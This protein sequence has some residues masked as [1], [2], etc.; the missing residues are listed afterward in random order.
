MKIENKSKKEI[1]DL[2]KEV[3]LSFY[4]RNIEEKKHYL[5]DDFLWIGAFDFQFATNK[6]QFLDIISSELNS[7]PF[8]MI[9]EEFSLL[10]KTR[11]SYIV[12]AKFKLISISDDKIVIRTHTRLTILWK[13]IH[14]ELKL[15]HVHGSNA[16]DI[17]LTLNDE[18]HDLAADKSFVDYLTSLS[19]MDN[20]NKV[21]FKSIDG[22]YRY[23]A[24]DE[25]IYLEAK[26]QKTILHTR[27]ET[28]EIQGLLRENAAKLPDNFFRIHKTYCVNSY[29]VTSLQ[30]YI[31]TLNQDIALPI[32]KEKYIP[33]RE[34]CESNNK[35]S[36]D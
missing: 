17:P 4:N 23:Y 29:L 15:I 28:I 9:D 26:L 16:Q 35:K 22:K 31:V 36:T 30:R 24:K 19:S 10:S 32:G 27:K 7:Q 33:F 1:L 21:A 6:D 2:S 25:I 12:Y 8:K 11:S 34:F 18:G 20:A 5:A 3:I 13:Y 14:G